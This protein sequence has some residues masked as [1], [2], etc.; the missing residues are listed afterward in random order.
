MDRD[1]IDTVLWDIKENDRG[2]LPDDFLIKR[3]LVYGGAFLIRDILKNYGVDKTKEVFDS[4]KVSE[5]GERRYY[6]FKNY[7]FI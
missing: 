1:K 6:F 2:S 7:L 4:L 3:T 5:V